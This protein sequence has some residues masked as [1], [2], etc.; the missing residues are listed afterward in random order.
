[1]IHLKIKGYSVPPIPDKWEEVTV[2]QYVEMSNHDLTPLRLLSI[3]TGIDYELISNCEAKGFDPTIMSMM[4]FIEKGIDFDS[5]KM[6]ETL[7]VDGKE[8]A[9]PKTLMRE[10]LGQKF[11]SLH[12]IDEASQKKSSIVNLI[13]EIVAIYLHPYYYETPSDKRYDDKLS[14]QMIPLIDNCKIVDVY[15][16]AYFFLTAYKIFE[17][18]KQA[19]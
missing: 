19:S 4:K 12:L 10:T 14:D 3:F 16:V 15:P 7:T 9:I 1:M 8:C 13:S 11:R 2:K 5:L 18:M 6:P 17:R